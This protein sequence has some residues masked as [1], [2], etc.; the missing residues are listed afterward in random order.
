MRRLRSLSLLP[1]VA[2]VGC[3]SVSG[4]PTDSN[5]QDQTIE[6][7]GD[8][9]LGY[10]EADAPAAA[11]TAQLANVGALYRGDSGF[12]S[13]T[14]GQPLRVKPG[15]S[16]VQLQG[17][18]V[19]GSSTAVIQKTLTTKLPLAGVALTFDGTRIAVDFGH[20]T[21][22]T[23]QRT[24]PDSGAVESGA[25]GASG[26]FMLW[27]GNYTFSYGQ[28]GV[29]PAVT[30][31]FTA[32]AITPFDVTPPEVRA[33]LAITQ[34]SRQ[35]P[36][37]VPGNGGASYPNCH[38]QSAFIVQRADQTGTDWNVGQV[39]LSAP[40]PKTN[41]NL[42]VFPFT[43]AEAPEHFEVVVNNV[44]M[45]VTATPGATTKIDIQRIDV[46]DVTV[47]TETGATKKVPGTYTLFRQVAASW[48]QM[49]IVQR[50]AGCDGI[51]GPSYAVFP[52][53]T[54]IDVPNGTYKAVVTY[55]TAA[56]SNV[57]TEYPITVP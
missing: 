18:L 26:T 43:A 11:T 46:D 20:G 22:L 34:P 12:L 21:S 14:I 1:L 17:G 33:T 55:S 28:L 48:V 6:P 39:H 27:P 42:R 31:T 25:F 38:A 29:L 8:E 32:G 19:N 9:S 35:F 40:L 52:T 50:S 57:T 23:A 30:Q 2:V 49:D 36:D 45:A 3:A 54:G 47:T 56:A 53:Q 41:A 16:Q 51:I 7:T 15:T 44:P 4:E 5:E 13:M 37:A 10:V 24:N